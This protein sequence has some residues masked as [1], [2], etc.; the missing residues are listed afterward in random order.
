MTKTISLKWWRL[1]P[2]GGGLR[3]WTTLNRYKA[4]G[5]RVLKCN[6]DF[7][8]SKFKIVFWSEKN[9][10]ILKFVTPHP[11]GLSHFSQIVG[12]DTNYGIKRLWRTSAGVPQRCW[13]Q[14]LLFR[15]LKDRTHYSTNRQ[16]SGPIPSVPMLDIGRG[17]DRPQFP[18]QEM[19]ILLW[20][21]Y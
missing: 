14:A 17:D 15:L 16:P 18:C 8:N 10:I 7:I 1:S 13:G 6:P 4:K 21:K 11:T 12:E 2:A 9:W 5:K 3:G 20:A 19:E